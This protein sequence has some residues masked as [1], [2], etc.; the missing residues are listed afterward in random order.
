MSLAKTFWAMGIAVI[1]A[2][3]VSYAVSVIYEAPK[4]Y[5][6]GSNDCYKTYNC[7][8]KL[9]IAKNNIIIQIYSIEFYYWQIF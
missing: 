5:S 4:D 8:S 7:H 2:V 6:Y 9:A 1:F 3:F